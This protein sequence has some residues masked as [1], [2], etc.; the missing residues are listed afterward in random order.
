MGD[1][2]ERCVSSC[3]CADVGEKMESAACRELKSI[4]SSEVWWAVGG[5]SQLS[6]S[7]VRE[8]VCRSWLRRRAVG[9]QA[10]GSEER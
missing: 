5:F 7:D 8:H 3:L 6:V 1:C 2:E 4:A 10:A 9:Y